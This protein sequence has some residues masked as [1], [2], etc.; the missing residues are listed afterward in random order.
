MVL[1]TTLSSVT[2]VS[3]FDLIQSL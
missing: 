2:T 3:K 1:K